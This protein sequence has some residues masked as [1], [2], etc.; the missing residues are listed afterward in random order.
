MAAMARY[1]TRNIF[2]RQGARILKQHLGEPKPE[3]P[4]RGDLADLKSW[5]AHLIGGE[6]MQS[7]GISRP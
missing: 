1:P 6:K 4:K 7:L 3:P 2:I 5:S